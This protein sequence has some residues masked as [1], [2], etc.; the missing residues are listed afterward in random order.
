[1]RPIDRKFKILATC[2]AHGHQYT[3]MEGM[4][5]KAADPG[6]PAGL[7]AYRHWLVDN[8]AHMRQI[9]SVDLLIERVDEFQRVNPDKVKI[10]DVDEGEEDAVVNRPNRRAGEKCKFCGETYGRHT[11]KP[12]GVVPRIACKGLKSGYVPAL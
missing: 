1:M 9:K 5:F 2:H 3:E 8:H 10:P 4:F 7:A 11:D 6:L 12:R